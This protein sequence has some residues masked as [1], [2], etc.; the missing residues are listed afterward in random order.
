MDPKELARLVI[1]AVVKYLN[2]DRQIDKVIFT[3][4]VL[5]TKD[6]VDKFYDPKAIF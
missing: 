1:E 5:I 2:G 4:A 6:N 3:P